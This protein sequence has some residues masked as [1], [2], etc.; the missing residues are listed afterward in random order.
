MALRQKYTGESDL[1]DVTHGAMMEIIQFNDS[2]Q[3]ALFKMMASVKHP[4]EGEYDHYALSI[5]DEIFIEI[6]VFGK[7]DKSFTIYSMEDIEEID[8]YLDY[9]NLKKAIKWNTNTMTL[10][11]L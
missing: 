9:I 1:F 3:D 2:D 8:K 6:G 10:T 11:K 7:N 5:D 4:G